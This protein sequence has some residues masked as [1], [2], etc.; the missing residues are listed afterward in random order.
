[1]FHGLTMGQK[2][3]KYTDCFCRPSLNPE[4]IVTTRTN[5]VQDEYVLCLKFDG[6]I[7]DDCETM[8]KFV[9][10]DDED[11]PLSSLALTHTE[12]IDRIHLV[13]RSFAHGIPRW[14]KTTNLL[15]DMKM[16]LFVFF[17]KNQNTHDVF[18]KHKYARCGKIEGNLYVKSYFQSLKVPEMQNFSDL[19]ISSEL[20]ALGT[21][22]QNL[23][24]PN[25]LSCRGMHYVVCDRESFLGT[26]MYRDEF[27][28]SYI[29]PNMDS[30]S[31]IHVM[32]LIAEH[33]PVY[34]GCITSMWKTSTSPKEIEEIISSAYLSQQ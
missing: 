2:L 26:T 8:H 32:F 4:I 10:R 19:I 12:C 7:S 27:A 6:T 9:G 16:M 1:M 17:D 25:L 18:S 29:I 5:A 30:V 13:Y 33:E 21:S 34:A 22:S 15:Q 31:F 11:D 14:P 24:S 23:C 20:D 3:T 28:Y